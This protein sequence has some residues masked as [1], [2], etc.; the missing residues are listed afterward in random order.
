MPRK[1]CPTVALHVEMFMF[2][3]RVEQPMME[4]TILQ[5]VYAGM[6]DALGLDEL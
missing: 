2:P 6:I 4:G 3:L 5:P 1:W